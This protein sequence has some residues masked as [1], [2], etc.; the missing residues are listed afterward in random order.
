MLLRL[1]ALD[2]VKKTPMPIC[3]C[4]DAKMQKDAEKCGIGFLILPFAVDSD[5]CIR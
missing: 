1:V 2:I 5:P 3:K 4:Y